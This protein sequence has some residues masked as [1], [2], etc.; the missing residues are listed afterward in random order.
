MFF[1]L[2]TCL[3]H[4]YRCPQKV[5]RSFVTEKLYKFGMLCGHILKFRRY[6]GV[7]NVV[8]NLGDKVHVFSLLTCLLHC[9]RCPQKVWRSFVTEK[10]Y[11]FGMLCGRILKFRR[12]PGVWNVVQN[13][14]DKVHVFSLLTCLL[15][16]YRCPLKVL[17]SLS[18]GTM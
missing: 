5:W 13:L 17:R 9:Y 10:L 14:D 6:P 12:H 3:L 18:D 7:W 1:S 4:C 16:C 15:H 8:Q 11:K 2:L